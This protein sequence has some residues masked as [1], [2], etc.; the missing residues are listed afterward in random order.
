MLPLVKEVM[1]YLES[2]SN[3]SLDDFKRLS[4]SIS[5]KV[6]NYSNSYKLHILSQIKRK[7]KESYGNEHPLLE[8]IIIEDNLVKELK[9][10]SSLRV[11]DKI[12]NKTLISLKEHDLLGKALLVSKKEEFVILGLLLGTGRRYSEIKIENFKLDKDPNSLIFSGQ[13]K[14][15]GKGLDYTIP[16]LIERKYIL[17][18]LIFLKENNIDI[19]NKDIHNKCLKNSKY[20]FSHPIHDLRG[21][22]CSFILAKEGLLEKDSLKEPYL[23]AKEIL[24]HELESDAT[25]AYRK[26]AVQEEVLNKD[27]LEKN[28]EYIVSFQEEK[29]KHGLR[30]G[31]YDLDK[32]LEEVFEWNDLALGWLSFQ[33]SYLEWYRS[34]FK[35]ELNKAKLKKFYEKKLEFYLSQKDKTP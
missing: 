14:K 30:L 22:Y 3:A 20:I 4:E 7:V 8:I 35:R 23:R 21:K 18:G 5:Y 12:N 34:T 9:R 2:H 29:T 32:K 28:L 13:L 24:G 6:L 15:K 10:E 19:E 26:Y 11:W 16:C 1:S 33:R 25:F 31:R 27:L 17:N